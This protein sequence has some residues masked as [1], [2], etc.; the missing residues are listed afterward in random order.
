V[1][2][3][4]KTIKKIADHIGVSIPKHPDVL[5]L[6]RIGNFAFTIRNEIICFNL[7]SIFGEFTAECTIDET[8]FLQAAKLLTDWI[9]DQLCAKEPE[10]LNK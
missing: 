1:K 6:I 4:K 5:N 9:S 8:G 3:T 10:T 7:S 2:A